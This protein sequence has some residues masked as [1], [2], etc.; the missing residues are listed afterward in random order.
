MTDRIQSTR[1][2]LQRRFK[3]IDGRLLLDIQNLANMRVSILPILS[4]PGDCG[5]DCE[6]CPRWNI[7]KRNKDYGTA[8]WHIMMG[9]E[10]HRILLLALYR[11]YVGGPEHGLREPHQIIRAL[12]SAHPLKRKVAKEQDEA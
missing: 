10:Q 12:E 4:C 9:L 5:L 7:S 1:F 3:Q 6:K 11:V 2:Q 8:I